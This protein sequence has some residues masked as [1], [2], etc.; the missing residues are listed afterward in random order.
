MNDAKAAD[1]LSITTA[2]RREDDPE[3]TPSPE[4]MEN[5]GLCR[6]PGRRDRDHPGGRRPD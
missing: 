3:R 2:Y 6:A 5:A 1:L 4:V